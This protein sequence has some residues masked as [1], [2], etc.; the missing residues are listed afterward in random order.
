MKR[1]RRVIG[2]VPRTMGRRAGTC[3][4]LAGALLPPRRRPSPGPGP[5]SGRRRPPR[6]S[7]GG[8]ESE[9]P[10]ASS[11]EPS[12]PLFGP[13]RPRARH[14]SIAMRHRRS[15]ETRASPCRHR[16]LPRVNAEA[17]RLHA[18]FPQNCANVI[19]IPCDWLNDIYRVKTSVIIALFFSSFVTSVHTFHISGGKCEVLF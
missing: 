2:G 1:A 7:R 6:S 13:R 8:A 17:G 15:S 10:D 18:L 11:R 14:V 9:W 19:C 16:A 12:S 3:A 5:T 4:Y